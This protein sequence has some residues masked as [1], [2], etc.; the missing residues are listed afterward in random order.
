M[1]EVLC[2]STVESLLPD[3]PPLLEVQANTDEDD[4]KGS[5]D[6]VANDGVV[7]ACEV[8]TESAVDK[9]DGYDGRA[10]E[11]V[12]LAEE[13][14]VLVALVQGVVDDAGGELGEDTE[15][16]DKTDSLVRRVKMGVLEGD[17]VSK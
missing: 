10:E 5:N 4:H 8:E 12:H 11:A 3:S 6:D 1:S 14:G 15:K 16:D 9:A 17:R 13:G 2:R 7:V